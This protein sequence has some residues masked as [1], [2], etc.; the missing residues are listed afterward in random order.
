MITEKTLR[1]EEWTQTEI[2]LQKKISTMQS[3]YLDIKKEFSD[4]KQQEVCLLLLLLMLF[5]FI[6]LL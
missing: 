3:D 4:L 6:V 5:Y 1:T 2:I